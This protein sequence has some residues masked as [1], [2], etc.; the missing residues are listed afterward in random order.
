MV[1][2]YKFWKNSNT[3]QLLKS[4]EFKETS[5]KDIP[6]NFYD[7]DGNKVGE[8]LSLKGFAQ[9]KPKKFKK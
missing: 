8:N 4:Q 7:L 3:G 1:T 9:I 2:I 6:I 5:I